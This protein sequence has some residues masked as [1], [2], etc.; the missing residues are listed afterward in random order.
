[1]RPWILGHSV[2]LAHL[3]RDTQLNTSPREPNTFSRF[4]SNK[5]EILLLTA[6]FTNSRQCP[7]RLGTTHTCIYHLVGSTW[8]GA[9]RWGWALAKD[10]QPRASVTVMQWPPHPPWREL[11]YAKDGFPGPELPGIGLGFQSV[12]WCRIPD[13]EVALQIWGRTSESERDVI[14]IFQ[15]QRI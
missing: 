9:G 14:L 11:Y 12:I 13:P 4:Q 7:C 6:E 10:Q 8:S 3:T 2:K 15:T 1:M 5:T